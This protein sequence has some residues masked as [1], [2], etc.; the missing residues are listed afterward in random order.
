MAELELVGIHADGEHIVLVDEEGQRHRLPIDDALRAAVRRDRPQLEQIRSEGLRPREIQSLVRAGASAEDIAA[1]AGVPVE[2]VRRYEGPALAERGHVAQRA[3]AMML[4]REP[5]SPTLGDM[6]VDRLAARGVEQIDWDARRRGAEP[7]EVVARFVAGDREREAT[8][9]VD[10][11]AGSVVAVDDESRWLS[12]TDLGP[13]TPRRHLSAVRGARLYDVETDADVAPALAAVDAVIRDT[14]PR[15][16]RSA[17]QAPEPSEPPTPQEPEAEI[18]AEDTEALLDELSAAR[19]VR[20]HIEI[21]DET[22]AEEVL[23]SDQEES[24]PR[25]PTVLRAAP[26]TPA[27]WD[28]GDEAAADAQP[29]HE[30]DENDADDDRSDDAADDSRPDGA[31]PAASAPEEATDATVIKE[32]PTRRS[33][34]NRRTSVPSWD[35]IV[36]GARSDQ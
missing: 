24:A 2:Q 1:E 9:Q 21:D 26:H 8:W 20:Q 11:A 12:E 31:H 34:K 4:G 25:P 18:S 10:L 19:G 13:G 17:R 23:A 16:L 28:E 6:V 7:W 36:F 14:R 27:L 30:A 29:E 3:Q 5:G 35:E 33:Q 22:L 32:R 15:D